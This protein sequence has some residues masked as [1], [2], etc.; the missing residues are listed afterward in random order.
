LGE[1]L[2]TGPLKEVGAKL[3]GTN[4][5]NK[6]KADLLRNKD[7]T[8]RDIGPNSTKKKAGLTNSLIFRDHGKGEK[9]RAQA[10]LNI[11]TKGDLLTIRCVE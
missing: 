3:G 5:R 8:V 11:K 7:L 1:E 9:K 6:E 10:G 2:L 4:Q